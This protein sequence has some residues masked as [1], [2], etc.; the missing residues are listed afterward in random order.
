MRGEFCRAMGTLFR[1]CSRW[2]T[3]FLLIVVEGI[4]ESFEELMERGRFRMIAG[5]IC[6]SSDISFHRRINTIA[7][8]DSSS[9]LLS[10]PFPYWISSSWE[11]SSSV[12]VLTDLDG[13]TTS[14]SVRR[15][16]RDWKVQSV[17]GRERADK[18]WLQNRVQLEV[19]RGSCLLWAG[20]NTK[21]CDLI[22]I[23]PPYLEG[24]CLATNDV[25]F[26]IFNY[27]MVTVDH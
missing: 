14:T 21:T 3:R 1:P 18:M 5:T 16:H 27:S 9:S 10:R 6:I 19:S 23:S 26:W 2:A 25:K 24:T 15:E 13:I 12:E 11:A 8:L 4:E 17:K 22:K 20:T 7:Y